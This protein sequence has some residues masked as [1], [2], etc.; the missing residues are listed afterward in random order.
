MGHISMLLFRFFFFSLVFQL[1]VLNFL[2][3][4]KSLHS[5]LVH[6]MAAFE[7]FSLISFSFISIIIII[8]IIL[9]VH[10]TGFIR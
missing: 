6:I 3:L 7:E 9:I 8:V 2:L 4:F 10:S 1:G 5:I